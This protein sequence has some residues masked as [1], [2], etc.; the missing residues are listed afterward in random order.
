MDLHGL[1]SGFSIWLA[2]YWLLESRAYGRECSA[3]M[4]WCWGWGTKP[5]PGLFPSRDLQLFFHPSQAS[6]SAV[7]HLLQGSFLKPGN[8]NKGWVVLDYK[9]GPTAE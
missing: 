4:Q 8:V 9:P 7:R 2:S 5:T 3:L 6:S 1:C